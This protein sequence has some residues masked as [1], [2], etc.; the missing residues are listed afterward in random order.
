[1][2]GHE[3]ART[4]RRAPGYAK[5]PIIAMTA[6]AMTGDREKSL[7]AGM[8]DHVT[9]PI[10]PDQLI[11]A[12]IKWIEPGERSGR[13]EAKPV[14]PK[15]EPENA[16]AIPELAGIDV[17]TGLSRVAGNRK[18]YLDLLRKFA[19]DYPDSADRIKNALN[20]GDHEL[21]LRLAHTVKG[22][23][24]NIGAM[25]LYQAA[26]KLEASIEARDEGPDRTRLNR[27]RG[28]PGKNRKGPIPTDKSR[29]NRP[30]RPNRPQLRPT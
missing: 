20:K 13:A 30:N 24:G 4:I 12:L 15:P 8:N 25:D 17:K 7:E 1:M 27:L 29:K 21:A 9:K 3:A 11:A 28:R 14:P 5:L 19:A 16:P 6:H 23:S 10:D 22:V 2:D 26:K 18:L